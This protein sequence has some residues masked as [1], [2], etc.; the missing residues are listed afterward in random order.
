MLCHSHSFQN[1]LP[2]NAF[3]LPILPHY[4]CHLR[5]EG[6]GY[7]LWSLRAMSLVP[8]PTENP[9]ATTQPQCSRW[10]GQEEQ[11]ILSQVH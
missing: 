7:G 9:A 8:P 10:S 6:Y 5:A 11:I 4:W 2:T 3:I 1:S